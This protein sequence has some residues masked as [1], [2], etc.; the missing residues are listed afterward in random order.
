M[1]SEIVSNDTVN[2][3]VENVE[4]NY[5]DDTEVQVNTEHHKYTKIDCLTED[6]PIQNQKFVLLSFI[7]PEGLMN[8]KTRGVKVRGVYATEDE[9][10]FAC[11]KLKKKDKDFDI[12]V[13]EMGKWLP[14]DPS[15]K[16]VNE[17]KFRNQRLDKLMQKAHQTELENLN[18]LV[19]RK[20][21]MLAKEKTAYKTRVKDSIKENIAKMEENELE[22]EEVVE[23]APKVPRSNHDGS[24]VR[25]RLKKMV[26]EREKNKANEKHTENKKSQKEQIVSDFKKKI[27]NESNRIGEKQQSV[28]QLEDTSKQLSDKINKMKQYKEKLLN[29]N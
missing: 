1:E 29:K 24:A 15:L 8:C 16:Q 7:S 2:H 13:G 4:F 25:N 6:K 10:K 27:D 14:W 11:E 3:E 26:E 17:V 5:Q 21:E 19:G 20:K 23:E 28:E 18:E 22:Q 12:F 9:A